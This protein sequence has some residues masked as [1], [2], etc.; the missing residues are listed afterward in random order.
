M[1]QMKGQTQTRVINLI[2]EMVKK[3][4]NRGLMN[5]SL[6]SWLRR[7]LIKYCV[8]QELAFD[9]AFVA[10]VSNE[11]IQEYFCDPLVVL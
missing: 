11:H 7:I 5:V 2:L 1:V 8:A 9:K 6:G 10:V 4:V 3:G